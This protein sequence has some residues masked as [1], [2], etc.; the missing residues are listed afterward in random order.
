M[1]EYVYTYTLYF[2]WHKYDNM[3]KIAKSVCA[4]CFLTFFCVIWN[5]LKEKNSK[6]KFK[7][8]KKQTVQGW[9]IF[10]CQGSLR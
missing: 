8:K 10:F 9:G 1:F 4:D 5:I 6:N 7:T 3:L 2:K